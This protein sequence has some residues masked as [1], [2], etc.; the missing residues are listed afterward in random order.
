[1]HIKF[2]VKLYASLSLVVNG[3]DFSVLLSGRFSTRQRDH[4]NHCLVDRMGFMVGMDNVKSESLLLLGIVNRFISHR[5]LSQVSDI[6]LS[7]KLE[8]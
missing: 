6:T 4:D 8:L 1:M 2:E 5:A 7:V 3:V